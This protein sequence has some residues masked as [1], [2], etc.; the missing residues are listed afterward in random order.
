MIRTIR[1][2]K[3]GIDM[4]DSAA[5]VAP[6]SMGLPLRTA[7]MIP[8]GMPISSAKNIAIAASCRVTGS[9]CAISVVTGTS[10][11]RDL[12]R[13]P[14]STWPAQAAYCTGKGSFRRYLSRR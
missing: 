4:P 7:A 10:V 8:I 5:M 3:W 11:R 12:P 6:I 14:C 1:S 9:F 2:E 13:S